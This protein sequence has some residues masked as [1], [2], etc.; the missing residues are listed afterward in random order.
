MTKKNS[1]WSKGALK[2]IAQSVYEKEDN[3]DFMDAHGSVKTTK[4]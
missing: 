1:Q 2:D 4:V 3:A